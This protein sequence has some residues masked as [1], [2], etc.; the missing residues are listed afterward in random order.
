MGLDRVISFGEGKSGGQIKFA[1]KQYG[2]LRSCQRRE[3]A[4][5]TAAD[6]LC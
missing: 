2:M 1:G 4:I 3:N 5:E 6:K